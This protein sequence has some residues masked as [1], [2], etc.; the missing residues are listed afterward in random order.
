[1]PEPRLIRVS[2][3]AR[4]P[5]RFAVPVLG[6]VGTLL[7]ACGGSGARSEAAR[8]EQLAEQKA[9]TKFADYAKCLREHGVNA[10]A[11]N[12]PNGGHG[13]RMAPGNGDFATAQGA[14][15]ACARYRPPSQKVNVSPQQKVE[16]EETSRKFA[17]CIRSHGI[18]LPEGKVIDTSGS[19]QVV[20]LPGVNPQSPAFQAAVKVCG[21]PKG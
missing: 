1:M 10:E 6:A 15:K 14:Q 7:A 2:M 12:Q 5:R 17:K 19:N 3:R 9:E 18:H 16:Q 13:I 20:Y 4:L 11:V 21:G 8:K